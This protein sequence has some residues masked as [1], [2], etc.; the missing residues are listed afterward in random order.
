MNIFI[1]GQTRETEI[2]RE[3]PRGSVNRVDLTL[4]GGLSP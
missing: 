1:T 3:G 2:E 4:V